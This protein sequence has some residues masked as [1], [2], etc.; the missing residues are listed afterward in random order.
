VGD[1]T[2]S[3]RVV[4]GASFEGLL[5][6]MMPPTP[7]EQ[8]A[9]DAANVRIGGPYSAAYPLETYIAVMK[10]CADSRYGHL[11]ELE[12]YTAVGRLFFQGYERTII[13]QALVA[14]VRV[15]G[16]QRT[17]QR[18]TRNFRTANNFTHC[19]VEMVSPSHHLVRISWSL[20]PGFYKGLLEAGCSRAGAKALKVEM[21]SFVD[22]SPVFSVSWE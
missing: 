4:F 14:V 15:L 1:S 3:E 20:Y 12:R 9:L 10:A 21:I 6:A 18:M 11:P 13:G 16:P 2:P 7:A 22:C 5:R 19:E 8:K 17:L